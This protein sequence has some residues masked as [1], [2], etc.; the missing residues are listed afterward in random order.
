MPYYS[1]EIIDEI[2]SKNDIVSVVGE[3]V[4]LKRQGGSYVGLCPFHNDRNP[5]FSVSPSKQMCHCFSCLEGGDVISFVMKYEVLSIFPYGRQ[6]F[7]DRSDRKGFGRG[8][9]R[10]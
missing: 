3:R 9:Y 6:C 10:T 8:T 4:H 1:Q 5:S 7:Q 2:I